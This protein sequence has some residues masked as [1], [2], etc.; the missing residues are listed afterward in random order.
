M[1]EMIPTG[2]SDLLHAIK[3]FGETDLDDVLERALS[4]LGLNGVQLL[5]GKRRLSSAGTFGG[6]PASETPLVH[7]GV[8]LV[9]FSDAGSTL[10]H[11]LQAFAS[12][13]DLALSSQDRRSRRNPEP[14][15]A[16]MGNNCLLYTSPSPRDR[17]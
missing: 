5:E 2:W 6:T 11:A 14:L 13:L 16:P 17:G 4:V 3:P 12:V 15:V 7:S 1:S 10:E 9:A 8:T